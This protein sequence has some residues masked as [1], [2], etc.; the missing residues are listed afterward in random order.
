MEIYANAYSDQTE[1]L[2][3]VHKLFTSRELYKKLA[4]EKEANLPLFYQPWWLDAA[5]GSENWEPWVHP[6]GVLWPCI[7]KRIL[8][9][10]YRTQVPFATGIGWYSEQDI[11]DIPAMLQQKNILYWQCSVPEPQALALHKHGFSA[12]AALNYV[13]PAHT[14][15]AFLWRKMNELSRRNINKADKLLQIRENPPVDQLHA[16]ITRSLKRNG[17]RMRYSRQWLHNLLE[18]ALQKD[19]ASSLAAQDAQGNVHAVALLV[20]DAQKVYY[21]FGG[22]DE[23]IPQVGASRLLLWHGIRAALQQGRTFD[24]HGGNTPGVAQVYASMGGEPIPYVRMVRYPN[25]WIRRV[26]LIAKQLRAPGDKKFHQ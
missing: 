21:L 12:M 9:L 5:V 4:V 2:P 22:L 1:T 15:E 19:A 6:S 25:D 3:K 24:F 26:V 17:I 20:R 14:Q 7:R 18:I 8:G 16:L 13:I 10:S 11:P 23:R